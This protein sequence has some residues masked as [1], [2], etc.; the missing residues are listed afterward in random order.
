MTKYVDY[1]VFIFVIFVILIFVIINDYYN[2]KN[3][4]EFTERLGCNWTCTETK[5]V[6][7]TPGDIFDPNAGDCWTEECGSPW[8]CEEKECVNWKCEPRNEWLEAI[9]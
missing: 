6:N 3:S 4:I 2:F 1:K 8:T 7:V 9:K 5:L